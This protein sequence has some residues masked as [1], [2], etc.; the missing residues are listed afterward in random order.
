MNPFPSMGSYL[1][2][3]QPQMQQRPA[4]QGAG[5]DEILRQLAAQGFQNRQ[6]ALAA[7][8][9]PKQEQ[10][11]SGGGLGDLLKIAATVAAFI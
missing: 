5:P 9:Q 8:L 11:Q 4:Y 6:N 10:K 7:M 1:Q 2:P 3:M